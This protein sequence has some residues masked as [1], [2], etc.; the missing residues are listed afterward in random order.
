MSCLKTSAVLL[1]TSV[2]GDPL[3]HSSASSIFEDFKSSDLAEWSLAEYNFTHPHF[4][5]DWRKQ[6]V[7]VS[8]GQLK[9]SLQPHSLGE[10]SFAG[11]ALRY[12]EKT[13]Y[14][15]YSVQM[16]PASGQGL[17]SGFFVYSGPAYDTRHDEIDIEFLGRDTNLLH[18]ATFVDGA[19]NN[20]FI[21]LG[22][23]AADHVREYGFDWYPDRVIWWVDGCEVFRMEEKDEVPETP[24][25]VF[26]NIW[27]VAPELDIWAGTPQKD[28]TGEATINK[29]EFKPFPG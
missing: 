26:A 28:A 6:N 16:R 11:S 9:L 18:V 5:T 14:G 23:N 1:T 8:G 10:N 3:S 13:H 20:Q 22:F 21:D 29:I 15:R 27:A 4:D 12:V 19:L 25:Y 2:W 7:S 17:V 24:G